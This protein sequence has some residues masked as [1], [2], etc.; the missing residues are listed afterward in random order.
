MPAA[1]EIRN[2]N[3]GKRVTEI[4]RE[5]KTQHP[6]H[7]DSHIAVCAEIEIQLQ[8]E[9]GCSKPCRRRTCRPCRQKADFF[10]QGSRPVGKK[11]LFEKP[12]HKPEQPIFHLFFLYLPAVQFLIH[13]GKTDNRP[14][15]QLGKH[16]HI[17]E[18]G[19][20]IFLRLHLFPVQINAVAH[21]LEG[22]KADPHGKPQPKRGERSAGQRVDRL[23][24]KIRIFEKSQYRKIYHHGTA[25]EKTTPSRRRTI[26]GHKPCVA[27]IHTGCKQHQQN[28][29]RLSPRIKNKAENEQNF[30]FPG[31]RNRI[32]QKQ[33]KRQE[34]KQKR[35]TAEN[36]CLL[37][38]SYIPVRMTRII[39][40]AFSEITRYT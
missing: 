37:R 15:H 11:H 13:R 34:E 17:G 3:G 39:S 2:R 27:V 6:A 31:K 25:E 36:H 35:D 5:M 16:G 23:N 14:C 4:L 24:Q 19:E 28:I 12:L 38:P 7:A 8:G 18:V 33:A 21:C 30:V 32:I 40:S 26:P 9:G 22:V 20:I 29:H 1:P 10:P